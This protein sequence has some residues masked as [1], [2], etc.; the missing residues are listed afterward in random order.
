M[1][2]HCSTFLTFVGALACLTTLVPGIV[3]AAAGGGPGIIGSPMQLVNTIA[4]WV[5]IRNLDEPA[6]N[7]V[8]V[9]PS[10][11]SKHSTFVL[12]PM[13]TVPQGE[14]LVIDTVTGHCDAA[15]GI[16]YAYLALKKGEN[17]QNAY[18]PGSVSAKN[19]SR[20]SFHASTKIFAAA[21]TLVELGFQGATDNQYQDMSCEP[22]LS[23]HLVPANWTP[24]Q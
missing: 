14:T 15:F 7:Y 4:Q 6:H 9:S 12:T 3:R 5:P 21:G 18:F 8:Q 23:G 24:A 16:G 19:S 22:T 2:K 10:V 1:K 11:M 17:I 20:W 13:Y